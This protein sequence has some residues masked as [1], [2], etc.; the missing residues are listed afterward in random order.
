MTAPATA[1]GIQP[2]APLDR[3]IYDLPDEELADVPRVPG[4]LAESLDA[5]ERDHEFLLRGGVFTEDV[6]A[7]WLAWKRDTDIVAMRS[8]PHPYEF[9]LYFDA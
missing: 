2:G 9:C 4:S 7:T 1:N 3:D 5:L 6:I 8:R